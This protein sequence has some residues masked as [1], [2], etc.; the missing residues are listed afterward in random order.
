MVSGAE[1]RARDCMP[2]FLKYI[3][4]PRN[5]DKFK[6]DGIHSYPEH[7]ARRSNIDPSPKRSL[8]VTYCTVVPALRF[9]DPDIKDREIYQ[10][11][12]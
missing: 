4:R 1:T 3:H 10:Y 11:A 9:S 5:P 6:Q 8:S 7:R 2:H 12:I